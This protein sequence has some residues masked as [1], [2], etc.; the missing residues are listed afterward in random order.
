M[1]DEEIRKR[2]TAGRKKNGLPL[3]ISKNLKLH[4]IDL[5]GEGKLPNAN[6]DYHTTK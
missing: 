1:D 4:M 5:G 6:S 3:S 2:F